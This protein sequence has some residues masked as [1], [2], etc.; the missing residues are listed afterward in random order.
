LGERG[1]TSSGAF[2]SVEAGKK[3]TDA[4]TAKITASNGTLVYA[5]AVRLVSQENPELSRQYLE[6]TYA[7]TNE[8]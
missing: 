5:E 6:E 3:F 4:V 2:Q 8:S 7:A 1:R